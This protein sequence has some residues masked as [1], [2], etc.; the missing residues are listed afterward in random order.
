MSSRS[1]DDVGGGDPLENTAPLY[2]Q[3]RT[4]KNT[5]VGRNA[6][7]VQSNPQIEQPRKV[8][9]TILPTVDVTVP[10]PVA[11]P[12]SASHH[13][14]T[15]MF[16][17]LVTEEVLELKAYVRIV[18]N[19]NKRLE[20]LERIHGE[21]EH[22]LQKESRERK[23][24]EDTLEAREREWTE[25]FDRLESER[26]H[27]KKVVEAEQTKNSRL[28][29]QVVRKDQ[30]IHRMLQRKVRLLI[31]YLCG[32]QRC[33]FWQ[34]APL[35]QLTVKRNFGVSF[36]PPFVN[37]TITKVGDLFA[38]RDMGTNQLRLPM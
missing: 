5:V 33:C 8:D 2:P 21:L 7:S 1:K 13:Q 32:T 3:E 25:K 12:N 4:N 23:H 35:S 28:I 29:D 18:E 24:L 19:Q 22:R 31:L 9:N 36:S 10:R 14:P 16:E 20:E 6:S 17:R 38:M 37:S 34:L 30:D 27:W 15:P 26:N 11:Y